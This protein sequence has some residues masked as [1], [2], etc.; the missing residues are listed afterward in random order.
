MLMCF[1]RGLICGA[2]A[3]CKAPLLSSNANKACREE[4]QKGLKGRT[5]KREE[6]VLLLNYI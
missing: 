2:V 4:E 5:V 6:E 3:R 1:V